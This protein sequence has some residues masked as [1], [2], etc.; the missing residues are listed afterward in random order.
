[1]Q[2][3]AKVLTAALELMVVIL[4]AALELDDGKTLSLEHSTLVLGVG[5]WAGALFERLDRGERAQGSGGAQEINLPR[6]CAA[7][8]LKI[9]KMTSRWRRSMVD[10]A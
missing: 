8:V 3:Q 4:D 5:E 10:Y 2:K 1:M 6:A 9:N 7:V